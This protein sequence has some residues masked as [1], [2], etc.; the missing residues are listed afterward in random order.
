VSL[1]SLKPRPGESQTVAG[2]FEKTLNAALPPL[3]SKSCRIGAAV[4]FALDPRQRDFINFHILIGAAQSNVRLKR[5]WFATL[6][7]YSGYN[8]AGFVVPLKRVTFLS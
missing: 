7:D 6:A 3:F 8:L 4:E 1:T 5:D 2:A